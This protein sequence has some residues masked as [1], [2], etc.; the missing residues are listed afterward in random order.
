[1]YAKSGKCVVFISVLFLAACEPTEEQ[2]KN[3]KEALPPG[4]EIVYN[5]RYGDINSLLVI[6]C[7]KNDT[8]QIFTNTNQGK[9]QVETNTVWIY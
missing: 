5:D 6:T 8:V 4:C 1:M 9:V 7:D 2:Q 3:L